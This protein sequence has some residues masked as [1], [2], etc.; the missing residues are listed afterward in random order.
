MN[1]GTVNV[2]QPEPGLR[3]GFKCKF[4][5]VHGST[6]VGIGAGQS[7]TIVNTLQAN[8]VAFSAFEIVQREFHI[9]DH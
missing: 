1:S 8:T 5:R 6:V 7:G 9:H 4:R 2:H 3:V